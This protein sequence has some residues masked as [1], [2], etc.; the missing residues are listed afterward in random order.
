MKLSE[1]VRNLQEARVKDILRLGLATDTPPG[2]RSEGRVPL[3]AEILA[4][5][6]KNITKKHAKGK[7]LVVLPGIFQLETP[8]AGSDLRIGKIS[9]LDTPTPEMILELGAGRVKLV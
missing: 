4:C 8:S 2:S 1:D 6:Q 5:S 9:K 7:Q 3:S